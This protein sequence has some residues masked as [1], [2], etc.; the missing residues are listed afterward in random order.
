MQET[1]TYRQCHYMGANEPCAED[2]LPKNRQNNVYGH[3]HVWADLSLLAAAETEY[4]LD[5]NISSNVSNPVDPIDRRVHVEPGGVIDIMFNQPIDVVHWRSNDLRDDWTPLHSHTQ[6]EQRVKLTHTDLA[7]HL[8]HLPETDL[9]GT[10]PSPCEG[11]GYL[12]RCRGDHRSDLD[13]ASG[14]IHGAGFHG[15]TSGIGHQRT[16]VGRVD[17]CDRRHRSAHH[18]ES[19]MRNRTIGMSATPGEP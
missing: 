5:A 19:T 17:R 16:F 6:G 1:A 15:F 9:E 14:R 3:G 7:H 8:E 18:R 2:L 13:H 11:R 10:T 4:D 12:R